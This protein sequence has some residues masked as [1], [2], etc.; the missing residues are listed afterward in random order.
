[1]DKLSNSTTTLF[2]YCVFTPEKKYTVS[3]YTTDYTYLLLVITSGGK[4]KLEI[5]YIQS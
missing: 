3:M 2:E 4:V 5:T 1:M